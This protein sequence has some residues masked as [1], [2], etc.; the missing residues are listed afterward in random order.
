MKAELVFK[1]CI[2]FLSAFVIYL[3]RPDYLFKT[4]SIQTGEISGL[5]VLGKIGYFDRLNDLSN[6]AYIFRVSASACTCRM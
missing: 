2:G 3:M 6:I 5:A 4:L 1:L